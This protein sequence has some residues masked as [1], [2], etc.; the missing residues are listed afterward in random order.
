MNKSIVIILFF[1]NLLNQA[2]FSQQINIKIFNNFK[3]KS[4]VFNVLEGKY[5]FISEDKKSSRI[6]YDDI[7]YFTI[8]GDSLSIWNLE[9]HIGIFKSVELITKSRKSVFQL[10]SAVPALPKR[11][12][13]DNLRITVENKELKIIN[14][15]EMEKYLEGVLETECGPKA[16]F[17][18]YKSQAIICRTYAIE[19]FDRHIQEGYNLCDGVHCQAYKSKSQKTD[20]IKMAIAETESLV[21]IDTLLKPITAAFHSNSGGQTINSEDV[22]T[23]ETSYL[24]AVVDTFALNQKNSIWSDTILISS[25]KKYIDTIGINCNDSTFKSTLYFKQTN[26]K[27]HIPIQND[28]IPLKKIR[29]DFQLRSTFFSYEPKNDKIIISGKGYGHGVGLS[30]EGA[31]EMAREGYNFKEIIKFYYKNVMLLDVSE[32]EIIYLD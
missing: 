6:K 21:I 14:E 1:L 27:T 2:T 17:E 20:S 26:R 30:Q 9:N 16:P 15:L 22:W 8:I 31:M 3:V 4:A 24:K 28:S 10:E 7:L 18:Y 25:W 19:H 23:S 29:Q 13:T 11:Y 32:M 5:D 12:Y